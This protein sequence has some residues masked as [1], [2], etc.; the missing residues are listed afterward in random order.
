MQEHATFCGWPCTG[1]RAKDTPDNIDEFRNML[2]MATSQ[3]LCK[4]DLVRILNIDAEI[5]LSMVSKAVV[6]EL[7]RLSPHGE[8]NPI[9]L[10]AVT[11]VKIVGQPRRIGSK[12]QH[13]SFYVKQG[14]VAVRAVAF[15]MGE[16]IDRLKQNGRTCSLAFAVKK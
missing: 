16:Q 12:G 7:G 9:P 3:R 14:E 15:G 10:F 2:N 4:T 11:N 1:G 6:A 13:L 5:T 8:G